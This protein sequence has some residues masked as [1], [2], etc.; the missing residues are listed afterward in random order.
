MTE[1]TFLNAVDQGD[2]DTV[3]NLLSSDTGLYFQLKHFRK[4][5]QMKSQVFA[6]F[7]VRLSICYFIV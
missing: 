6:L 5:S 1:I 4:Y 7:K 3:K 2:T